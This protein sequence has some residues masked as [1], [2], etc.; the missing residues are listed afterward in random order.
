MAEGFLRRYGGER[1]EVES[2]GS[3]PSR[4]NE[5]AVRVMNEIGIDIAHHRSKHVKEFLG[6]NFHTIITVCDKARE[7]C[8]IFP[9]VSQRL[10]WPFPDP[11]HS[12]EVTE[13]VLSEFRRVRDLIHERFK[14][15][16]LSGPAGS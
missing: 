16:A 14:A 15:F 2:A 10:H 5:T 6:K 9:G 11:S 13:E 12:G 1:F 3:A 8:P 4:V 7:S